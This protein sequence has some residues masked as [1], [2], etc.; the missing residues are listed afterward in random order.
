MAQLNRDFDN[1]RSIANRNAVYHGT[2]EAVRS[3]MRA[4]ILD[5][6]RTHGPATREEVAIA[7]GKEVH[8]ISGR[9]TALLQAGLIEETDQK[10]PTRSG[11]QAVVV[12]V[13][14]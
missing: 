5:R 9:F 11:H 12:R 6:L 14:A 13:K 8:A 3:S 4:A 10:R 7:L 1:A 2:P